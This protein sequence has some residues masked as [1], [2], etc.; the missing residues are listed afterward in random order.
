MERQVGRQLILIVR[1]FSGVRRANNFT[2]H[3][4]NETTLWVKSFYYSLLALFIPMRFTK[5]FALLF[6]LCEGRDEIIIRFAQC[7][8]FVITVCGGRN[9]EETTKPEW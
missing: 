7:T 3:F 1:I 6:S 5:I 8:C 4:A 2:L 9:R